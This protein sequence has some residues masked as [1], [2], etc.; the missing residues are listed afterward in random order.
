M[1]KEQD[2]IKYINSNIDKITLTND[3]LG[4]KIIVSVT[5]NE[6]R[7]SSDPFPDEILTNTFSFRITKKEGVASLI[8]L[9]NEGIHEIYGSYLQYIEND[10]QKTLDFFLS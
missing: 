8:V 6:R 4:I 3:R 1:P 2:K 9:K 7:Y 10:L 5:W